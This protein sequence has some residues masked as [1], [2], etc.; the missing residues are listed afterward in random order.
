MKIDKSACNASRKQKEHVM[1]RRETAWVGLIAVC[2]LVLGCGHA[3]CEPTPLDKNWG[4]S[5][6]RAKASQRLNPDAPGS[7]DPVTGL[8]GQAAANDMARYRE[9][10]AS[11]KTEGGVGKKFLLGTFEGS[12]GQ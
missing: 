8:D 12:G 9:A 4:K 2:L 10:H 5:F 3:I 11:K 1:F 6:E 7:L